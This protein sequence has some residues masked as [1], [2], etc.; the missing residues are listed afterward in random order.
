[1]Q[2]AHHPV[3]LYILQGDMYSFKASSKDYHIQTD[4][5]FLIN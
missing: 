2:R 4:N 1:M 5:Q 3:G